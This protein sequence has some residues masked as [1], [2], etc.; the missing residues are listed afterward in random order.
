MLYINGADPLYLQLYNQ[1]RAEI[2]SGKLGEGQKLL[3]ERRLAA[4]HGISRVTARMALQ[5]L[6]ESGYILIEPH[7]GAQVLKGKMF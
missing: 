6:A 5:C 4:E 7:K 2:D 3:S 1:I